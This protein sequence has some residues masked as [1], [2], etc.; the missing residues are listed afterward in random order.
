MTRSLFALLALLIVP[1]LGTAETLYFFPTGQEAG[2]NTMARKKIDE[3]YRTILSMS[4]RLKYVSSDDARAHAAADQEKASAQPKFNPVLDEA[5]NLLWKGKEAVRAKKW[6]AAIQPLTQALD[7][8]TENHDILRDLDN[9]VDAA[10][11][12]ALAYFEAQYA[13]NADEKIAE[14]VVLRPDLTFDRSTVSKGFSARYDEVAKRVLTKRSGPVTIDAGGKA[15]DVYLD[16]VLR[17]KAP[18]TLKDLP[19]GVHYVQVF[20]PGYRAWGKRFKAPKPSDAKTF[21]ATLEADEGGPTAAAAP[22]DSPQGR[23]ERIP[24][25]GEFVGAFRADARAYC[26]QSG[27]EFLLFGYAHKDGERIQYNQFVY[28]AKQDAVVDAGYVVFEN[29]LSDMQVKVLILEDQLYTAVSSFASRKAVVAVPECYRKAAPAPVVAV[30]PV[31][32]PVSTPTPAPVVTAPTSTPTP[33]SG[34]VSSPVVTGP[35]SGSASRPKFTIVPYKGGATAA[36]APVESGPAWYTNK[37]LWI[38]VGSAVV[39]AGAG[40]GTYFLLQRGDSGS[41]YKATLTW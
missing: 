20:S 39:L 23:L 6:E 21:T 33:A 4:S 14:V 1:S 35:T 12:L 24:D 29:D 34:A 36:T 11:N 18:V 8:Y 22:A 27:A 32:A 41:G 30:A 19:A 31:V 15:V 16:G 25:T 37:W 38:G 2:L 17:G 3:Y 7:T 5:N 9:L 26:T 10:F 28:G 40:V 13:D